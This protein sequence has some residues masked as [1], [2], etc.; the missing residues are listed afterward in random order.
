MVHSRLMWLSRNRLNDLLTR[1]LQT[2]RGCE[3]AS[4]HVGPSRDAAP[5][6]SNWWNFGCSVP[7]NADRVLFLAV[8]GGVVSEARE[9][10]NVLDR[11]REAP[12]VP[13][14]ER[15]SQPLGRSVASR[16]APESRIGRGGP[17]LAGAPAR[18]AAPAARPRE[19]GLEAK[20]FSIARVHGVSTTSSHLPHSPR[21]G[22]VPPLRQEKPS[23]RA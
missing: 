11:V 9:Q 17:R 19:C 6:E 4:I 16:P 13:A 8:A 15:N 18:L 10:Y 22:A 12:N 7:Q 1:E 3:G 2:V 23:R 14:R 20:T 21:S 5:G